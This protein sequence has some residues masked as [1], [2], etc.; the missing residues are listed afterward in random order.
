MAGQD[1]KSSSL[2]IDTLCERVLLASCLGGVFLGMG[3]VIAQSLFWLGCGLMTVGFGVMTLATLL[4]ARVYRK[5][6]ALEEEALQWRSKWWN[7]RGDCIRHLRAKIKNNEALMT[8]LKE[9]E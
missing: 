7:L 6:F 8:A 3:G 5:A 2:V 4:Q 1:L 9:D